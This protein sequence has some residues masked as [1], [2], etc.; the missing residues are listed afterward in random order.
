MRAAAF[1]LPGALLALGLLLAGCGES[2]GGA[3][4]AAVTLPEEPTSCVA[5]GSGEQSGEMF[6][7]TLI[8]TG[9]GSTPTAGSRWS[10]AWPT[11]RRAP[12]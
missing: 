10:T 2:G 5:A 11:S 8:T 7:S 9:R 6:D 3:D 4:D 12:G 1:P